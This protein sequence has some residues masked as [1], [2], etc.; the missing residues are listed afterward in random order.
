MYERKDIP[1][2]NPEFYTPEA[3]RRARERKEAAD[4][5][6]FATEKLK[7]AL[8]TNGKSMEGQLCADHKKPIPPGWMEFDITTTCLC[9][10]P[11]TDP[12]VS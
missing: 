5:P 10:D 3:E 1:S 7:E 8:A 12:E 4:T 9:G 6:V 2:M 11:I